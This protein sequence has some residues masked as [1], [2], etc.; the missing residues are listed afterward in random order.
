M[1]RVKKK[2]NNFKIIL[3]VISL[4]VFI[5][6]VSYFIYT[7]YR[8][9]NMAT[10]IFNS[11]TDIEINEKIVLDNFVK[12]IKNGELINKNEE[13]VSL[14]FLNPHLISSF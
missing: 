10:I 13:G 5:I 7:N 4:F 3:I 14:N 8:K 1:K 12:K 9:K 6:L 2:K 11:D